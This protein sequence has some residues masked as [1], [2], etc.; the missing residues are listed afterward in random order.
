MVVNIL[1]I[2]DDAK[3]YETLR[4]LR[5]PE[6]VRCPPCDSPP[7]LKQ[8]RDATQPDRP[9]YECRACHR[10]FD[11]LTDTVFAGHHQPLRTWIVVRYFMG[12]NRSNEQIAHELD[13]DP[14]DTQ[15]MTTLLREG[16]IQRQPAVQLSGEIAC[17][18]VDVVAG[19]KGH[20]EAVRNKGERAGADA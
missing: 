9:H 12:L 3:C 14:D 10:R 7:V 2:V 19:P 8:G 4:R 6:G 13:L 16:I 5:W 17:D 20:P 11:D 18:E 1:G 15:Q